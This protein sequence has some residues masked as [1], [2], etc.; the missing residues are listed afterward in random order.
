MRPWVQISIFKKKKK[1]ERKQQRKYTEPLSP[2]PDR[3]QKSLS[4]NSE[5]L[6]IAGGPVYQSIEEMRTERGA[7]FFYPPFIL[8]LWP[9]DW[10]SQE[11]M[12][13]MTADD[14]NIQE[15]PF[16]NRGLG[17]WGDTFFFSRSLQSTPPRHRWQEQ[18]E[19]RGTE[20]RPVVD[21]APDRGI[22]DQGERPGLGRMQG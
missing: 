17:M 5:N 20:G 14:K 22:A 13:S 2:W 8:Q 10:S 21:W 3:T 12:L 16:L 9:K 19:G 18:T 7:W 11:A 1:K 4:E 15:N 6:T